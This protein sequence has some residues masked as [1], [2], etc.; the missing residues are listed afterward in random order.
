MILADY[1]KRIDAVDR[2][3]VRLLNTRAQIAVEIWRMKDEAGIQHKDWKREAEI[4]NGVANKNPGPL[5]SD[6][7]QKIYLTI[8][9]GC[10]EAS[11]RVHARTETR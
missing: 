1:R 9:A 4:L 5:S 10:Q 6:W 11:I 8:L 3:L 7:L 2:E